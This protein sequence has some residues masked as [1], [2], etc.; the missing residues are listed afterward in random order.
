LYL[1]SKQLNPK[2]K[3]N[4]ICLERSIFLDDIK[5]LS[6][7]SKDVNFIIFP[8]R[9]LDAILIFLNRNDKEWEKLTEANYHSTDYCIS[10]RKKYFNFLNKLVVEL[11]SLFSIDAFLACNFGYLSQQE[12]AKIL[13][14]KNIAF[15]VLHKEGIAVQDKFLELA[16]VYVNHQFVGDKM[17]FYNKMISNAMIEKKIPGVNSANTSVVG[18]PRLD[19]FFNLKKSSSKQIVFFSF[20]SDDKFGYFIEDKE[21]LKKLA[22]R[23]DEFHRIIIEFAKL[24]SD[25]KVIIK[26]KTAKYYVEYVN[27]IYHAYTNQLLENLIITNKGSALDLTRESSFVIGFNS[28]TLLSGILAQRKIFSP[29]FGDLLSEKHWDYFKDSPELITYILSCED[30]EKQVLPS[31]E[32]IESSLETSK[33]FLTDLIGEPDGRASERTE[34]KIIETILNR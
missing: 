4:V 14:I 24:H 9:D 15:I 22:E 31:I 6:K 1:K 3:Y 5:A 21:Q 17:L 8:R 20:Y 2:L 13:K 26:T 18:I 33:F 30:L 27:D 7:R 25:I 23:S 34:Q 29:Y 10:G 32:K 12:L 19:P 28:V 11:D 16:N